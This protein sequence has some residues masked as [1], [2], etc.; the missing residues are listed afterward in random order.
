MTTRSESAQRLFVAVVPPEHAAEHLD[1]LVAPMRLARPDLSWVAPRR[2]HVTVAFM[3]HVPEAVAG[4]VPEAVAEP[5]LALP[6]MRLSLAG[7][8]RFDDRVLWTSLEG[9]V[10]ALEHLAAKVGAAVGSG[11]GPEHRRGGFRPHLSLARAKGRLDARLG[12][13]A[14]QLDGYAGPPWLAG[15]LR[16]V[17]SY[18]GRAAHHETVA[19]LPLGG[20]AAGP[21]L[22]SWIP[23]CAGGWC[24]A[25]SSC[26]SSSSWSGSFRPPLIAALPGVG[27]G[28]GPPGPGKIASI[29]S[30][31]RLQ[32]E[33]DRPLRPSSWAT[34]RGPMI[35]RSRPAGAAARPAP[36]SAGSLAELVA[37]LLLG[38]IARR[39]PLEAPRDQPDRRR[40]PS[41]AFLARRRAGRR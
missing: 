4:L 34:V 28:A 12:G 41:F 30:S 2:W 40:R 9:E 3:P 11:A 22:R 5:A 13:L 8:G 21:R 16:V 27:L 18:L 38:S 19:V 37:Q 1:A 17:R 24:P 31:T 20:R 32:R 15:E 14:A 33:V 6:P 10:D 35:G 26:S 36:T 7:S 25:C 29:R 39:C 23:A